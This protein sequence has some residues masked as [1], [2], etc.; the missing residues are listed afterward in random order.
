[1]V[2]K[3]LTSSLAQLVVSK[4]P[5]G[6]PRRAKCMSGWCTHHLKT[7]SL[8]FQHTHIPRVPRSPLRA[9]VHVR[10]VHTALQNVTLRFPAYPIFHLRNLHRIWGK[11]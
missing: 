5:H 2:H 9:E 10:M 1:M 6:Q 8:G 7:T 3:W 11:P 4:N